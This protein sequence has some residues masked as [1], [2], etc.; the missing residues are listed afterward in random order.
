MKAMGHDRQHG[1]DDHVSY[2][3]IIKRGVLSQPKVRYAVVQHGFESDHNVVQRSHT[4][5]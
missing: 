2:E 3:I 4:L 1:P 5:P